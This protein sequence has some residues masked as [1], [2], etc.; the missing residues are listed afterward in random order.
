MK[1]F[2]A[3]IIALTVIASATSPSQA[4]DVKRF[5]AQEMQSEG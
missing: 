5:R 1:K 3:F 2:I 4:F